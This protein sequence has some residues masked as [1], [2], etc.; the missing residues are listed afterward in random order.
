MKYKKI[1]INGY[2]FLNMYPVYVERLYDGKEP[3]KI[4]GIRQNQ[5]ELEGDF[6]AM[7]NTIGQQWFNHSEVFVVKTICEEQLK[8][9]G[10]QVHNIYCC[11][12]GSVINTHIEYWKELLTP[13][14]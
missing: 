12:G 10:C 4:V 2:G 14:K 11:G 6:S 5:V 9:N 7:N 13:T 3:F 8:H 1:A